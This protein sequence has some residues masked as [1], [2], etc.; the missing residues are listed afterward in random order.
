ML[1]NI[2]PKWY[3]GIF[4]FI[5]TMAALLLIAYPLQMNWGM[6]G[7]AVTQIGLLLIGLLV[8]LLFKWKLSEIM[9]IKKVSFRQFFGTLVLYAA[10]YITVLA[11]SIITAYFFP[12]LMDVSNYLG[13]FIASV[14]FAVALIIV[15]VMPGICEEVLFRGVILHT[16]RN[17][18]SEFVVML[19]AAVLFGIFHLDVYRFLP[20]AILGFVMTYLMLKTQ[21]FLLPVFF[22]FL[23]NAVTVSAG[24][25]TF[26]SGE[27]A[28]SSMV[29]GFESLGI[30]L[31]LAAAA[32]FL[33]YFAGRLLNPERKNKKY[34]YII[35]TLSVLLFISGISFV[36]KFA[37]SGTVIM[38]FTQTE[39]VDINTAPV[40]HELK[41]E[42]AGIYDLSF[43][44]KD[45]T[46][47]IITTLNVLD[48]SGESIYS[49]GFGSDNFFGNKPILLEV[50]VYTVEF[51]FENAS[52][53]PVAVTFEFT[54]KRLGG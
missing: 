2:T 43:S 41:I 34:L 1:K 53:T 30:C 9:P 51:S 13:S 20:T 4:I 25:S 19:I 47:S 37:L 3:I 16:M 32:P 15:A 14:P 5:F 11:V 46:E 45:E 50:G 54:A 23:N 22:H 6:Y 24:Y 33:F 12:G 26:S 31:L 36:A 49:P 52:S 48:K 28:D 29:I 7:L 39:H 27:M 40:R 42:S 8:P 35:I 18:K 21:N 44:I 38:N 17:F 10:S